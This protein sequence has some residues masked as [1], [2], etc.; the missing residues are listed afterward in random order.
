M[1]PKWFVKDNN[2]LNLMFQWKKQGNFGEIRGKS[3][4]YDDYKIVGLITY[5]SINAL[6]C[7]V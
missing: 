2:T 5:T 1:L 4:K 3:L 6:K 7:R